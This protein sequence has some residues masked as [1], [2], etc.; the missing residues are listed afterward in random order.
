MMS[1][2]YVS[3]M[4]LDKP[5]PTTNVIVVNAVVVIVVE[6]TT[7]VTVSNN[8]G[9]SCSIRIPPSSSTVDTVG[10]RIQILC[11]NRYGNIIIST[12][13]STSTQAPDV[14]S[15]EVMR[16]EYILLIMTKRSY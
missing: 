15:E 3:W 10:I 11:N 14:G 9:A 4:E 13:T 1:Q 12:S 16:F 7:A 8:E 2:Q 5:P 6:T